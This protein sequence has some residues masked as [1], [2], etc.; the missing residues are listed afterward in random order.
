MS[1]PCPLLLSLL[2]VLHLA[3]AD[4]PVCLKGPSVPEDLFIVYTA[5]DHAGSWL[6][7][8]RRNGDFSDT[9]RIPLNHKI[10]LTDLNRRGTQSVR[11][12]YGDMPQ[13]LIDE[14]FPR[15][16]RIGKTTALNQYLISLTD[17]IRIFS[18]LLLWRMEDK[19]LCLVALYPS[20]IGRALYAHPEFLS[21]SGDTLVVGYERTEEGSINGEYHQLLVQGGSITRLQLTIV[22]GHGPS[23]KNP[24]PGATTRRV[25]TF[26]PGK[27]GSD[28]RWHV[29]YTATDENGKPIFCSA[30]RDSLRLYQL[31]T[32][33]RT[34]DLIGMVP[35]MP[36]LPVGE[37]TL[38][39]L[40]PKVFIA[41][42]YAG[43]WYWVPEEDISID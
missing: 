3:A 21:Q 38:F 16:V 17:G 40:P 14:I 30:R 19:E 37:R 18:D 23:V 42:E 31:T 39:H 13:S 10:Q 24:I 26:L 12:Y 6:E 43:T 36:H 15:K 4:N 34:P 20:V 11:E 1:I 27:G 9:L 33:Y 35:A 28:Q 2:M 5:P 41:V 7:T 25:S 32:V 22:N 8:I 29:Y